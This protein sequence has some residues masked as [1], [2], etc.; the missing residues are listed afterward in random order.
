MSREDLRGRVTMRAIEEP[1]FR[2]ALAA[3]LAEGFLRAQG[4]IIKRAGR[5]IE[6]SPEELRARQQIESAFQQAG[7]AVPPV[8]D[9][10]AKLPLE[11]RR[12]QKILSL[13]VREQVLVK[14]T[15]E[16][17]FHRDALSRLRNLLADRRNQGNTCISVP[18]FKELAGVSRKY[19]IPLL[20]YLDRNGVTR[21]IGD[22]RVIL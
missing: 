17:L 5:E 22:D 3:L 8:K 15:E 11:S 9:V 4:E 19:A 20:E 7:L 2:A 6:L 21:R 18:A 14:V 1:L 12:A 10:L 16:L 13:L